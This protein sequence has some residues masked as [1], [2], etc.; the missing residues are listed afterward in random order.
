MDPGIAH[1]FVGR[2]GK[3]RGGHRDQVALAGR[4]LKERSETF[5]A[6]V[7]EQ[8]VPQGA[9][10]AEDVASQELVGG[11]PFGGSGDSLSEPPVQPLRRVDD[12]KVLVQADEHAS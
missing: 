7:C 4:H 9:I 3:R 5:A 11:A 8:S 6:L 10:G 1:A 2:K 12:A